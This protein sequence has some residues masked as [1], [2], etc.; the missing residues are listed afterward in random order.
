MTRLD[1]ELVE[2]NMVED[3]DGEPDEEEADDDD[4]IEDGK[5]A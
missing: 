1:D 5:F 2:R 3:S 4:E